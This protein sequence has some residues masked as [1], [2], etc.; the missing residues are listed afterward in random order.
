MITSGQ[1]NDP[2]GV[3][4]SGFSRLTNIAFGTMNNI[5]SFIIFAAH[6]LTSGI[7]EPIE[8]TFLFVAPL[9]PKL[10]AASAGGIDFPGRRV[11]IQKLR[12]GGEVRTGQG[13]QDIMLRIIHQRNGGLADFLQI[14]GTNEFLCA[15]HRR[16]VDTK[17]RDAR[18]LCIDKIE[19]D[20]ERILPV[21]LTDECVLF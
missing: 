9:C 2:M 4:V 21:K 1:G 8:F 17:D 11:I 7:T 13:F 12:A 5:V 10:K 14:E 18:F 20:G 15:Y 6:P 19:F 3:M 16:R